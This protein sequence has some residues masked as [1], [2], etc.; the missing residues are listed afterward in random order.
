MNQGDQN[1]TPADSLAQPLPGMEFP[2]SMP[3]NQATALQ[4]PVQPTAMPVQPQMAMQEP[5]MQSAAHVPGEVAPANVPGQEPA[6]FG[7][8]G[9]LPEQP[10]ATGPL[11][12]A[13]PTQAA[14]PEL[15]QSAAYQGSATP[16]LMTPEDEAD[17]FGREKLSVG[18]K[19]LIVAAIVAALGS[20]VAVGLWLYSTYFKVPNTG[21]TPNGVPV[22]NSVN[23]GAASTANTDVDGDGLT[24]AD[25]K[26]YGS[27]PKKA[28]TDGDGFA[29]GVEVKNGYSPTGSGRLVQ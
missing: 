13:I 7:A 1:Q 6:G 2:A 22:V 25:E 26:K 19:M 20:V 11:P 17:L 9:S 8:F 27:D 28:D 5:V 10:V 24:E 29:D 18:S 16:M 23:K 12:G 3:E 14:S 21:S 15:M 4:Q